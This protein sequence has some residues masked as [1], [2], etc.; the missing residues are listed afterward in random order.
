MRITK[1]AVTIFLV[2]LFLVAAVF[3]SVS[4]AGAGDDKCSDGSTRDAAVEIAKLN[5]T[6]QLV[7]L[8]YPE[9]KSMQGTNTLNQTQ[10]KY[11]ELIRGIREALD[12]K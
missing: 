10:P 2:P 5:V 4:Y 9:F 1:H 12:K 11:V 3:P 6:V 7:T 8:F